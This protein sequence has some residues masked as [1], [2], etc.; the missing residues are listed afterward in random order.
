M[1]EEYTDPMVRLIHKGWTSSV[2]HRTKRK[3]GVIEIPSMPVIS[4]YVNRHR[5]RIPAYMNVF[6]AMVVRTVKRKEMFSTPAAMKAMDDEWNKL[7]KQM[8][9][10]VTA[11]IENKTTSPL[12]H[13]ATTSKFTSVI[14][15]EYVVPKGVNSRR[16]IPHKSGKADSCSAEVTS[17]M[18]TMTLQFSVNYRHPRQ[19]L[20]HPK[21]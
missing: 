12:K 5:P 19:R 15:S 9:W 2:L 1:T 6:N 18:N 8:V 20:K 16:T 7:F 21:Q 14:F 11:V 3:L 4:D 17:K 13:D 10:D